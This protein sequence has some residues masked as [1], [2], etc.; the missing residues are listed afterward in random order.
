MA[1]FIARIFGGGEKKSEAPAPQ[2]APAPAPVEPAPVTSPAVQARAKT[3]SR[4]AGGLKS[5]R[6]EAEIAKK[7]LLGQ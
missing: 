6:E 4:Y 2:P 1:S 7:M 5:K 3:E